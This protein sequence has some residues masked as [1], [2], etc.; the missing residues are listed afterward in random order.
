VP[1]DSD[2]LAATAAIELLANQTISKAAR[3][4]SN[5]VIEVHVKLRRDLSIDKSEVPDINKERE[6][7]IELFQKDLGIPPGDQRSQTV[8]AVKLRTISLGT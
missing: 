1:E 4:L 8:P 6:K 3:E 7:L 5:R 2:L